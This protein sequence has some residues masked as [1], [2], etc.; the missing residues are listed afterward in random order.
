MDLVIED[1]TRVG[2]VYFLM[3]EDNVRK[4][5]ALPWVS[6]GSDAPSQAAE[7]DFIV[8]GV[9]RRGAVTVSVSTSGQAPAL[10]REL[11][12]KLLARADDERDEW[13]IEM[14]I[15]LYRERPSATRR[16]KPIV[17]QLWQFL[18]QQQALELLL[19]KLR[20]TR[21]NFEFLMQVQKTTPSAP[22]ARNEDE[23]F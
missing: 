20:E 13:A 23:D 1:G 3:S 11:K 19:S 8:P 5:I 12:Q 17:D 4:Q 7:G 15:R 2:T 18:E 21:T 14:E 22:A 6:F 9:I 16:G 10:T